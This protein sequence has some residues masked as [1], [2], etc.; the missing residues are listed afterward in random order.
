MNVLGKR[1]H[2]LKLSNKGNLVGMR[3]MFDS[4]LETVQ[5]VEEL[6]GEDNERALIV[7]TALR[8][9]IRDWVK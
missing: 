6:T 4:R 1:E 9:Q 7:R 2:E 8:F 5:A 3:G